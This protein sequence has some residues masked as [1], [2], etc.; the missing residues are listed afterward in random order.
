MKSTTKTFG[1]II[2]LLVTIFLSSCG[3]TEVQSMDK[4]LTI[5]PKNY[6]H[7]SFEALKSG[8]SLKIQFKH[9]SGPQ[10][11]IA[12]MQKEAFNEFEDGSSFTALA[13]K[14]HP[15]YNFWTNQRSNLDRT[16]PLSKNVTYYVVVRNYSKSK[17]VIIN[18]G[19]SVSHDDG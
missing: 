9:Q 19:L 6:I 4:P 18:I 1:I 17:D 7:W 3:G 8:S 10:V 12:V 5:K 14:N 2:F 15:G 16:I 11:G 13:L